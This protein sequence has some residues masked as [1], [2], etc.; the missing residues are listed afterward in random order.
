MSFAKA[1]IKALKAKLSGKHVKS[2]CRDGIAVSYVEGW[3]VIAEANRIFGFD[4]WD[5]ETILSECIWQNKLQRQNICAY[6]TRVRISVRAGDQTVIREG[7][8]AGYGLGATPGEAH[9]SA[10]KQAETDASKRALATFGNPFG[11]ALYE[12]NQKGV[13]KTARK[14]NA[15]TKRWRLCCDRGGEAVEFD[16][17]V[18]LFA[19][20]RQ[21]FEKAES[22]PDLV[23]FWKRN[24]RTFCE[25][26]DQ[27]PYLKTD[28]DRHYSD[29]VVAL[30]AAKLQTLAL[31]DADSLVS[32][33]DTVSAPSS[34]TVSK[35]PLPVPA[36][37]FPNN[38]THRLR[39]PD[40]LRF[41]R[42]KPC[43][44]CE[45][46]PSHAHHVKYAQPRAMS[47]KVSDEW[48]VPLCA[49]H[50]DKLHARG[51]ERVWWQEMEIDPLP[52]AEQLWRQS[53]GTSD[54]QT[55]SDVPV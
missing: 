45:R 31:R 3:H 10:V 5:R 40:H 4:G 39:D 2:V 52:E 14:N 32:G 34:K 11:L 16:V 15:H 1:Q 41:V 37:S 42:T 50:H 24:E 29:F 48:T 13:R 19:A 27:Y 28:H 22:V 54:I 46:V 49:I 25:L 36:L 23:A 20:A 35:P 53:R 18:N 47:R 17:P 38:K 21:E 43:L 26:R 9:E 30:Y 33:S 55:K 6:V 7:T 51:D 44:I 8:G 12:K